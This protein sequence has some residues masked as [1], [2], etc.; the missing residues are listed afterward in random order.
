MKAVQI[1]IQSAAFPD[2]FVNDKTKQQK[3]LVYKLV[4]QYNMSGLEKM[5]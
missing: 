2:Q 1:D 4:K 3:S 5:A